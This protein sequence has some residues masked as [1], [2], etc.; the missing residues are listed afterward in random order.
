[1]PEVG[2]LVHL[3]VQ[4]LPWNKPIR[5]VS[6]V[7]ILKPHGSKDSG[8]FFLSLV[9]TRQRSMVYTMGTQAQVLG[10]NGLGL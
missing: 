4:Q 6:G 7:L 3:A 8:G 10:L 5:G 1:M 9:P 2:F